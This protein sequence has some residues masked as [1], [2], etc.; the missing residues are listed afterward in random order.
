MIKD[1]QTS[2]NRFHVVL[3]ALVTAAS[4]LLAWYLVIGNGRARML[5]GI[6]WSRNFILPP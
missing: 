6:R 1:N 4:Y 5:A 2:L 3:D